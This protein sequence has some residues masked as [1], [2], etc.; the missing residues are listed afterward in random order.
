MHKEYYGKDLQIQDSL[1]GWGLIAT[2]VQLGY[3]I[4]F[5][6]DFIMKG[7][8]EVREVKLDLPAIEY[9]ICALKLKGSELSRAS[10]AFLDILKSN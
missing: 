6:P 5:V 1:S 10:K 7:K 3:G 8:K 4:G 9:T 2:F